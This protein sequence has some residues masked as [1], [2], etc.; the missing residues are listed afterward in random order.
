MALEEQLI[1]KYLFS[2]TTSL[3]TGVLISAGKE[4]GERGKNSSVCSILK[5]CY[6]P[7]NLTL[8]RLNKRLQSYV[9]CGAYQPENL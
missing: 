8:F 5:I 2:F 7:C 9:E 4:H 6:V 1:H 3:K